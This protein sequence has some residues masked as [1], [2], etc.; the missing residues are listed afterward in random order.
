MTDVHE[1]DRAGRT[2]LHYAA[3]DG[4]RDQMGTAWQE[5][6]PGRKAEL[7]EQSVQFRLQNIEYLVASGADVNAKDDQGYTPLHLAV[8]A[9][10]AEVV[11]LLLDS[12]AEV[13][14]V[15]NKGETPLRCAVSAPWADPNTLGLLR[16]RGADPY[17]P[18]NNGRSAIDFLRG[19]GDETRRAAFA[20]L[21]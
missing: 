18:S 16:E 11:R 1:R 21:L 4:P 6:D 14:A 13:D 2:P 3:I 7:H 17:L 15:N 12:G 20:D 9:D 10:S 19:I 5:E 8:A